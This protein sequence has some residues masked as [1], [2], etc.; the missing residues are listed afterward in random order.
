MSIFG[1][2]CHKVTKIKDDIKEIELKS[3]VNKALVKSKIDNLERIAS[4]QRAAI[5]SVQRGRL[6][7]QNY[8][9]EICRLPPHIRFDWA[10]RELKFTFDNDIT[11]VI[12]TIYRL[13]GRSRTFA[14]KTSDYEAN[15]L[16]SLTNTGKSSDDFMFD[17]T[18][19]IQGS[20][21]FGTNWVKFNLVGNETYVHYEV[22]S[23]TLRNA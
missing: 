8:Y 10:D 3:K 12:L 1:P 2:E 4:A 14:T 6:L 19:Y 9:R 18:M 21:N 5:G 22:I 23:H 17:S 16:Y 7:S 20:L 11:D 13:K 15:Q